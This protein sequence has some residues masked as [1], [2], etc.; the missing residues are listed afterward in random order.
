ML[1]EVRPCTSVRSPST[2]PLA[3]PQH[4]TQ[5][6]SSCSTEWALA[7]HAA[8]PAFRLDIPAPATASGNFALTAHR[9]PLSCACPALHCLAPHYSA[10]ESG[11][12]RFC[13]APF[14]CRRLGHVLFSACDASVRVSFC[15]E[16]PASLLRCGSARC[17]AYSTHAHAQPGQD[18]SANGSPLIN[19]D[20]CGLRTHGEAAFK[21]ACTRPVGLLHGLPAQQIPAVGV[22]DG[23]RIDS[24]PVAVSETPLIRHHTRWVVCIPS[25]SV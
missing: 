25:G 9:P 8:H 1:S 7:A 20:G 17:P 5:K 2:A 13:L 24:L 12:P 10:D 11:P 3:R 6:P 14:G 15:S 18:A 16:C 4:F 23:Q 22:G 21:M 19:G